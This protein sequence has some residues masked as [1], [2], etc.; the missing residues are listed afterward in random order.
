LFLDRFTL[1]KS[2]DAGETGRFGNQ[3]NSIPLLLEKPFGLGARQYWKI[4]QLDP[5]NVFINGFAAYGWLGGISYIVL[6]LT[7][8]FV[9]FKAALTRSPWQRHAIVVF[10][11]FVAVVF[12][13][14]QIDTDHWRHFY[15]MLGLMWG[16]FAASIQPSSVKP[17]QRFGRV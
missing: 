14:V 3:L 2:Y 6:V 12:Q 16:L 13:G 8:I 1:V 10:C 15:W 5:H 11:P 7:T 4:Y 17:P 9:G